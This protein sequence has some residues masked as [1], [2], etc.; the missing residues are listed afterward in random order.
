M[1]VEFGII[2]HD[3]LKAALRH[4]ETASRAAETGNVAALDEATT[5]LHSIASHDSPLRLTEEEWRAITQLFGQGVTHG[6]LDFIIHGDALDRW[7][8]SAREAGA[9]KFAEWL[10]A[11]KAAGHAVLQLPMEGKDERL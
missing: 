4:G 10:E 1:N 2:P 6:E 5:A 11:A 9:A 8:T 3:Q 7:I